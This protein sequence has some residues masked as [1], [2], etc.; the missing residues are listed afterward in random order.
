V[1]VLDALQEPYMEVECGLSS[2]CMIIRT[3]F[4]GET[5]LKESYISRGK[6][7]Y[8]T[9]AFR[10]VKLWYF[11]IKLHGFTSQKTAVFIFTAARTSDLTKD[12][13]V[14]PLNT[15][16]SSVSCALLARKTYITVRQKRNWPSVGLIIIYLSVAL[17]Q[18][19]EI[20]QD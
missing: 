13:K 11:S 9:A 6:L 17:S 10:A 2:S 14:F 7:R 20:Y 18:S 12:Y 3:I 19:I 16:F 4:V 8:N 5:V 1:S 15:C